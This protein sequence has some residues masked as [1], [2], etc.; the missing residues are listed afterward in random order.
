M[1]KHPPISG[2]RHNPSAHFPCQIPPSSRT[3]HYSSGRHKTSRR[4][5]NYSSGRS[6]FFLNM[7]QRI[8]RVGNNANP[9]AP[10]W[11]N[12]PLLILFL[13]SLYP[14]LYAHGSG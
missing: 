14:D 5:L 2:S 11:R 13:D 7:P 9:S 8:I 10:T 4:A 12:P 6:F 3:L 1:P